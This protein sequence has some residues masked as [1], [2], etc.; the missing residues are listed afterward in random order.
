M[1]SSFPAIHK[2]VD[3]GQVRLRF[4]GGRVVEAEAEKKQDYLNAMLDSDEGARRIGE[5]GIGTNEQIN[6]FTKNM[7]FDEKIGGTVHLALG[8]SF[9]QTGGVNKSGIHWD[10]LCDM[11]EG[12][13]ISVDG[14]RIYESGRF[15]I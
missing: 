14:K 11:R 15:T 2:G 8:A 9:P 10:L 7:L 6:T 12:G 4:E 13:T 1:E 5:F 3:V